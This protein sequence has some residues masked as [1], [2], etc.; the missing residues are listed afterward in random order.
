MAPGRDGGGGMGGRENGYVLTDPSP[1]LEHL[2]RRTFQEWGSLLLT[3]CRTPHTPT[4]ALFPNI[5]TCDVTSFPLPFPAHTYSYEV[6]LLL[7]FPFV[8]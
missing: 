2:M 1:L 6:P 5:P 3:E 7:P 4:T 8:H